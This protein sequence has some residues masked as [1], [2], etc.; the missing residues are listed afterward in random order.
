MADA[1]PRDFRVQLDALYRAESGRIR[2]TLIR[3]LGDFELAEDVMHDAFGAALLRWPEE[4][5]P[6]N[7]RAWLIS[8]A[9]FKAIDGFRRRARLD[10]SQDHVADTLHG[11]AMAVKDMDGAEMEDD[12][13]RL[14]FVCCHPALSP[15]SRTALTLREVCGLRTEEIARAFLV[16]APTIAQRIVRAKAKIRDERI[17]YQV[18]SD[19]ELFGRLEAVLAV[20]YLLFNEG[21]SASSGAS[22]TRAD[23]SAEAIRLGRMLHA[24]LP[25]PEVLG[26]L[27]L[28]LLQESR[29]RARVGAEGELVLLEA[30]DRAA[31]DRALIGEGIALVEQALSTRRFGPY[32]L[33]AAIAA[34]HAEAPTAAATD[35]RQIC[36]LYAALHAMQPSPVIE[37]NRAV[38]IAMHQGPAA[39]LAVVEALLAQGELRDY[40][41]AH[42]ARADLRRRLGRFAEA[43][44]SYQTAVALAPSEP[45]RR[46]LQNRL[47][48][49]S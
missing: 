9:R 45:E 23:L 13:L 31:W 25:E 30:Q 41:L 37:L 38:A 12:R 44:A 5:M 36:A 11:T 1:L 33:Q 17:A 32:T 29:R 19:A 4:G 49:L 21:Y 18:P 42:A 48:E 14:I 39:G 16:S 8:T 24:L 46:Y 40:Y 27:A 43:R 7:P 10:A 22:L 47:S 35:W 15:E 26:L 28:M 6:A 34:V 3:L 20:V 2:A